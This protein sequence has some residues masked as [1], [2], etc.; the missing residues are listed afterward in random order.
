MLLPRIPA[1]KKALHIYIDIEIYDKLVNLIRKKFSKLHGAL[2]ME[3]QDAL[4]HWI[5]EHDE[6]LDLYTNSHKL[7]NPMLPRDHI[8]ARNIISELKNKGFTLQCSRKDL[9]RAIENVRGSDKRTLIKWTK[10]VVEH[11]YMKWITHRILEIV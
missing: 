7:V 1:G 8:S 11:G 6:S 3:V 10:F 2:S 9:W 4:A 5:S